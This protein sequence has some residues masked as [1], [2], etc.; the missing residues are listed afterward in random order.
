[1]AIGFMHDEQI[2][3]LRQ[4]G[5]TRTEIADQLGICTLTVSNCMKR[6]GMTSVRKP[7]Y[8]KSVHT[9]KYK[10]KAAF[11]IMIVG[12]REIIKILPTSYRQYD[13]LLAIL[14][15]EGGEII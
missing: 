2:L 15:R 4:Q 9:S 1:M 13:N 10:K 12:D 7:K 8:K 5:L 6:H 3:A 14:Q 11:S